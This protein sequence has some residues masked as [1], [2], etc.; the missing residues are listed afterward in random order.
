VKYGSKSF[1]ENLGD[2]VIYDEFTL[3]FS[4]VVAE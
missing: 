4:L 2:K 1:F 3:D